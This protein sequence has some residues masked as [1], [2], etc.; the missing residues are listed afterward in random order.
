MAATRRPVRSRPIRLFLAGMFVVP[1]VSL[2][3]LWAFSAILTVPGAISDHSFSVYSS[4]LTS[5]AV[6]TLTLELPTEQQETY[7]WLLSGR[8]S[9]E[10]SLL[11][12]RAAISKALPV[13][14]SALQTLGNGASTVTMTDL[15]AVEAGLR[16]IPS[17]RQ[18]VD[19]GTI[20]PA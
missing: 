3:G 8:R 19:A 14:E 17:L 4:T 13:A 15:N 20:A 9:S 16:R 12:T 5:P 10:S 2:V 7:L 11:A 1:L 18:S 6:A